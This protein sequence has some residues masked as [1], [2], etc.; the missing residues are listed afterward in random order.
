MP[1]T[2]LPPQP[3]VAWHSVHSAELES[4]LA[5]DLGRGIGGDEVALRLERYGPNAIRERPE[6]S[7]VVLFLLQ[8]H[9]PLVY[10][11]IAA[12]LLSALLGELVDASVI[13]GVVLVNAVIGYAQESKARSAIHALARSLTTEATVLREG[14]R[15][16]I[17]ASELVLGDVVLL[18]AGDRVPADLRLVRS[19][20]LRIDESALT[21]E[22]VPS[23]KSVDRLAAETALADRSN[24]AYSSTLVAHGT[25]T[26]LVVETGERTQ[27]GR[28]QALIAGTEALATPLTRRVAAFSAVLL[29]GILGLGAATF[30]VGVLRGEGWVE[31]F[32]AAVALAVGAIPE[33]L[34]A[35][36]TITLAI[37][38]GKMARR[39][40][41]IRR[42][43]AVETLGSATIICSD[44]TGTL[45]QN[46]MTVQDVLAGGERFAV[47]GT[48]Y[49][50]DGAFT[51]DGVVVDPAHK[52]ALGEVLL[53]GLLCNEAALS[54]EGERW[55]VQGDPTEGALIASA[56]KAGL[57]RIDVERERPRL[58]ALP[59]ESE[60]RYMATLHDAGESELRVVY[61]KGSVEGVLARCVA[62]LDARGREVPLDAEGAHAVAEELA[63]RG[64]RVLAFARGTLPA[65][66]TSIEHEDLDEGLVF[67]GLQA[68][69]D[70]PRPEAVAAVR[71]CQSAGIQV[72]MITGDHALTAAAIAAELG[73]EGRVD[74][75]GDLVA[76]TGRELAEMSD[77]ELAAQA[78]H[79]AV[80]ARIEPEQKL[81]IVRA[82]QTGDSRAHVVAM[83]GD[84][85]NDAPALRRADIGIAMAITGTEVA[86]EAADM[87]LADDNF[88][89]IEAAI[90]EGR[91][92]YDNI[93]KFITWTLPTNLGEGFVV[94][95]AVL[96]G[97]RLPMLPVQIL[98][99]NMTTAVLLG[100]TLAFEPKEVGVMKRPPRDPQSPILS[101]PL[102]ERIVLVS[103][104]LLLGSFG[105]FEWALAS[106]RELAT[107]RTLAVNVFVV[108]EVFYLFNCRSLRDS[109]FSLGFFSNPWLLGGVAVTLGLQ[110]A[111]TYVPFMNVA[112]DTAPIDLADWAVI[113]AIGFV[114][115][116]VVGIEKW[117]RDA[118]FGAA[119]RGSGDGSSV[120]SGPRAPQPADSSRVD[121]STR[122]QS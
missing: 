107:A 114:I 92:V 87:V 44:K 95:V 39:H 108:G 7:R 37:G 29:Y 105:L 78:R 21:G 45:T 91:G 20:E 109:S 17:P 99:V 96:A 51:F 70:P 1:S 32:M 97:L 27:I 69:I 14:E 15:R 71:A 68:M 16:R 8:L 62:S 101:R 81:R 121:M 25:A 112:F 41:V 113:A 106:G 4:S 72:K 60:R 90:E 36:I 23:S 26:G 35:A 11:L 67:L 59:F 38:V 58:D 84:G 104:L 86:V 49:D 93:V 89:S 82:L 50:R 116:V 46:Q 34:P 65:R 79:T 22:S 47:E 110:L 115:H 48:G 28:V 43:P 55:V 75:A 24:M 61:V 31:M 83:T 3:T 120:E 80:F 64:R 74:E 117:L 40:A 77:S 54:R 19:R 33:G 85:V 103:V 119:R 52:P 56:A 6:R 53:A 98:W 18:Q 122:P 2:L 111:F 42:L 118:V 66:A 76:I 73:L 9:Q 100:L 13:F 10:V 102:I 30:T 94:L 12:G 88:S 57:E 63:R 5:T